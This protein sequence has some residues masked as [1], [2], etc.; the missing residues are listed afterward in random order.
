MVGVAY[1]FAQ[2]RSLDTAL[3]SVI[4]LNAILLTGIL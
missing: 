1:T 4:R 3:L 2:Y